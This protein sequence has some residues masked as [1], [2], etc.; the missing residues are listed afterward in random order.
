MD[1][2][3]PRT[4]E[5][6]VEESPP[7]YAQS[8]HITPPSAVTRPEPSRQVERKKEGLVSSS[9]VTYRYP[10]GTEFRLSE[11]PVPKVGELLHRNGDY[12]VVTEVREQRDGTTMV[13][14]RPDL[15]R[16][17]NSHG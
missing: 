17:G 16:G 14:L 1:N 4:E 11:E 2:E 13:T 3:G 10:R 7:R 5:G 8:N 9:V 12:W 15:R 6:L